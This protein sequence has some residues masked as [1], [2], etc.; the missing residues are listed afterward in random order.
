MPAS[1][2]ASYFEHGADIGIEG[3][4]ATVEEAFEQ[5]ARAVFAIMT[6]IDEV[7]PLVRVDIAFAEDDVELALV[8]WLNRLLAEAR[9]QGLVFGSFRLH[10]SGAL[11][12]GEALGEPWRPEL[13]RGVEVKGATLTMLSVRRSNGGWTA[14][15]VVDV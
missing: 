4:G 15:C 5:A 12:S 8:T 13:A 11:W 10:R 7:R 14:R 2:S 3:N 9:I 6:D 1:L